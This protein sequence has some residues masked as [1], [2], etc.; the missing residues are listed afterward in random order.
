MLRVIFPGSFDP[1]TNG[2]VN[3]IERAAGVYDEVLV[4][5]AVNPMKGYTFT[6]EERCDM[7]FRL[8][9]PFANV[10]VHTWDRLIV[11]FAEKMGVKVMIRGVR[12]LADFNYE[13]E[14]S[15]LNKSLHPGVET[16]FMPT[17]P[18]FFVLRSSTIKEIARFG[19]DIT[20]MVPPS[21]ASAV[22]AKVGAKLD[23]AGGM[24]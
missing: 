24:R 12:A 15:M 16:I 7:M 2:H 8:T 14:L 19:G 3:V 5:I 4:V 20:G 21:V 9:E 22:Y 10:S 6:A 11:D 23:K 13:F 18:Q 1:P 17:D